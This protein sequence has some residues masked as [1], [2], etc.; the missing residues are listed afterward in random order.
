MLLTGIRSCADPNH[1]MCACPSSTDDPAP[2]RGRPFWVMLWR[3]ESRP[4][5]GGKGAD[6][7][8]PQAT[9]AR[10]GKQPDGSAA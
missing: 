1:E 6:R 4:L 3:S 7:V 9:V 2:R 10:G 5:N 8:E